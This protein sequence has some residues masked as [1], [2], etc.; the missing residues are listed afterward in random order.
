ME[1]RLVLVIEGDDQTAN[2]FAAAIREADYEVVVSP[3]AAAGIAAAMEIRPDCVI[4]DVELPDGDG[5]AVARSIRAQPSP[6]A[7][8]PLV[9]L[10]PFEEGLS[11]LARFE[12]GADA[13]TSQGRSRSMR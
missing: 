6:V 12:V 13:F 3:T 11:Q 4:C 7:L 9:L 10:S 2:R 1:S 5:L 8:T